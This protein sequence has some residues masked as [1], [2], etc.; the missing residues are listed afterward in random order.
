[1]SAEPCGTWNQAWSG[2]Q[3]QAKL[4]SPPEMTFACMSWAST[5]LIRQA[6]IPGKGSVTSKPRRSPV[7]A[8]PPTPQRPPLVRSSSKIKA[9]EAPA[10]WAFHTFRAKEHASSPRASNATFP[11]KRPA[12]CTSQPSLLLD[13]GRPREAD[14][15][16]PASPS[17]ASHSD[18]TAYNCRG[19]SVGG[20]ALQVTG[21]TP[22][23]LGPQFP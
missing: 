21:H 9:A 10:C 11:S 13:A 6:G 17:A 15:V 2:A 23:I 22:R 12:V 14:K 16:A 5:V 3:L 4:H 19:P 1:M 7:A 20:H 8:P 18:G